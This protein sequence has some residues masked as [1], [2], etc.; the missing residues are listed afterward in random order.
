MSSNAAPSMI[1]SRA[2][3]R[4]PSC[5]ISC[6]AAEID[7]LVALEW[8]ADRGVFDRDRVVEALASAF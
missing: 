8:L 6:R 5:L 2:I 4:K 1:S 7:A 3:T